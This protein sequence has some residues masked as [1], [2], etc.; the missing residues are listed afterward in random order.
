MV[1][2]VECQRFTQHK[3]ALLFYQ[4]TVS[5]FGLRNRFE[6]DLHTNKLLVFT[7]N[8]RTKIYNYKLNN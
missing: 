7:N 8:L 1:K 5:S 6:C 4:E 3:L 2:L